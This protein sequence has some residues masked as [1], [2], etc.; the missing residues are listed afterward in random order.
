MTARIRPIATM[1]RLIEQWRF[2][3]LL[4]LL[5]ASL[6]LEPLLNGRTYG[7]A[8]LT[9]L[10]GVILAGAILVSDP[11]KTARYLSYG[12]VVVWVVCGWVRD[13]PMTAQ[14]DVPLL[15]ITMVLG[16][17][18]FGFTLRALIINPETDVDAL[19]GAVFGYFLLAVVWSLFYLQLEFWNPGSFLFTDASLDVRSE[20]LY[21]SLV[22]LTTLGYGDITA[23]NPFARICSGIEAAQGTLYLAILIGRVVGLLRSHDR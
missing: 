3:L 2:R 1:V 20:L 23:T 13:S 7:P 8:I 17:T 18:V 9:A 12:L 5:L 22:T 10:F 11:P 15:A 6:F 4:C 16:V 19:A 21:F 14:F